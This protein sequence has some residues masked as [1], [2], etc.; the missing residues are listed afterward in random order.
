MRLARTLA[1]P[2]TVQGALGIFE[3]PEHETEFTFEAANGVGCS[4]AFVG[5]LGLLGGFGFVADFLGEFLHFEAF[6]A[7]TREGVE[8]TWNLFGS[9]IEEFAHV[10]GIGAADGVE[11]LEGE[12]GK[13]GLLQGAIALGSDLLDP[14]EL[15]FEFLAVLLPGEPI[16]VAG[17]F[18]A[19]EIVHLEA[20]MAL[21]R[22]PVEDALIFGE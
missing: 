16:E 17:V 18:P 12:D 2:C 4:S 8:E 13:R 22:E 10:S 6:V 19:G 5:K 14:V 3:L 1:L 11:E 21:I 7:E 20:W 9:I 15:G